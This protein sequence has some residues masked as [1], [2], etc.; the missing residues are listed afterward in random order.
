MKLF[1]SL[2]IVILFLI[3]VLAAFVWSG[4]YNVAATV[5]HSSLAA[6]FLEQVRDRSIEFHSKGIQPPTLNDPKFIKAG[7]DEYHAMCRLCHGAPGYPLSEIAKGL[8]PK[9]PDFVSNSVP[10]LSNSEFYWVVKNGIRMTGMPAFGPTHDEDELWSIVAF[11]RRLPNL[12]SKEYETL[13]DET[14]R[15]H[16][17]GED[18]HHQKK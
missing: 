14:S 3:A 4:R 5:P 17:E 8:N 16:R 13:A 6:W 1:L 10:K 12:S 2:L 7:F 11:V 18:H 15:H 9:P